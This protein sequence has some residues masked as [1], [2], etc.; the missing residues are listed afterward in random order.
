[1]ATSSLSHSNCVMVYDCDFSPS[2]QPFLVMEYI[3]GV[4]LKEVL[5]QKDL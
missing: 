4:S 5:R 1:M 2:G 3:E